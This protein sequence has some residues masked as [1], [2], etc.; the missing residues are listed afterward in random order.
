MPELWP[1][2]L[3]MRVAGAEGVA[4][5]GKGEKG[6]EAVLLLCIFCDAHGLWSC[7]AGHAC[8]WGRGCGN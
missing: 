8:C 2:L 5:E 6:R 1:V 4:A 3:N 7:A